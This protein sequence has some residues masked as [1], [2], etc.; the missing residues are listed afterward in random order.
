MDTKGQIREHNRR[1][2]ELLGFGGGSC[3]NL[4]LGSWVTETE[5][6][7]FMA[8]LEAHASGG[9]SSA[10]DEFTLNIPE[11]GA[12][13]FRCSIGWIRETG[14]ICACFDDVTDQRALE[15]NMLRHEKQSLLD[16]LVGGIAHELNNKLTPVYGYAELL[17]LEVGERARSYVEPITKSVSEAARIVRQLLELSKPTLHVSELVDLRAVVE[18]ALVMLRFELREARCEVRSLLPAEPLRVPADA[19]QIKQVVI[20]LAIN[21]LHAMEYCTTPRLTLELRSAGPNA[22]LIIADTG[23]GIPPENL[24]RIFD[25]YFTTKGPERGTGLGLSICL[26]LM[27]QHS[28]DIAVESKLGVGTRFTVS[29]PKGQTTSLMSFAEDVDSVSPTGPGELPRGRRVL[30][31]EDEVVLRRLMQEILGTRFGC[32]V[33]LATNG[34]DAQA[35]LERGSYALVLSD[36]RMP[37][38]N[39]T[40]LYLWLVGARPEL[41]R[42]FVFIT[43]QPGDKDLVMQTARWNLP[44]I[45][46]PFTLARLVDV[47]GPFLLTAPPLF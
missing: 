42:R 3:V 2:G 17:G 31:V 30:V 39:G 16:T 29:L 35:M 34:Q 13:I 20:N 32:R 7:E 26:S 27:R 46:K 11:R 14:E 37:K 24:E 40:E 44:V 43:G 8:L 4:L 41:A 25:P 47:C 5:R 21:A 33:D 12:R 38:M 23:C 15:R 1:L 18:E 45:A 6:P 10:T 19:S 9:T 36:I 22:E 28:G